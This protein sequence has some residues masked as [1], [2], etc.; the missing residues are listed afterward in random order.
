[1]ITEIN[2]FSVEFLKFHS[3]GRMYERSFNFIQ[4][5]QHTSILIIIYTTLHNDYMYYHNYI[6]VYLTLRFTIVRLYYI[7]AHICTRTSHSNRMEHKDLP[8]VI[9]SYRSKGSPV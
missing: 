9:T 4:N 5:N 6:I 7:N 1:M 8:V 3:C 2:T